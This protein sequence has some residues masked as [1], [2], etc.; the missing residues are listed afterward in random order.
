MHYPWENIR[1]EKYS[2]YQYQGQYWGQFI[3]SCNESSNKAKLGGDLK[4]ELINKML[5]IQFYVWGQ[6]KAKNCQAQAK[7]VLKSNL[8]AALK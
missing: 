5:Y 7:L 4:D 3:N 6:A 8:W 1:T 2:I